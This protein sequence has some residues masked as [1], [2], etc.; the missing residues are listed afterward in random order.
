M[1]S[2]DSTVEMLRLVGVRQ[3]DGI[4]ARRDVRRRLGGHLALFF[5]PTKVENRTF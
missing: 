4:L 1:T 5:D 3:Q 2:S